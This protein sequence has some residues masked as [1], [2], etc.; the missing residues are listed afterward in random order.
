VISDVVTTSDNAFIIELMGRTPA[1]STEWAAQKDQ[2]RLRF[3]GTLQEGHLQDWLD[4]LRNA[5]RI[6]DRRDEVLRAP[7]EEE[8]LPRGGFGF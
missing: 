2:Q 5:A 8:P 7:D 4:G 3:E 1:D 6:V